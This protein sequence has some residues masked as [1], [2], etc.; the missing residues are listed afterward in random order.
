M[1]GTIFIVWYTLYSYHSI[2]PLLKIYKLYV[3]SREA[4]LGITLTVYFI[5]IYVVKYIKIIVNCK[6]SHWLSSTSIRNHSHKMQ[7]T[8]SDLLK[9]QLL[10]IWIQTMRR[11]TGPITSFY[12]L[13]LWHTI[14]AYMRIFTSNSRCSVS[15]YC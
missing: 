6:S 13:L 15:N 10:L 4:P 5:I 12:K 1:Y 9:T 7:L 3:L 11:Q 2:T 8:R 14:P